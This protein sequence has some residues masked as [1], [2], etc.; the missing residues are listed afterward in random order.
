MASADR[1]E[2]ARTHRPG[3]ATSREALTTGVGEAAR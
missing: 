3:R 1:M 2:E